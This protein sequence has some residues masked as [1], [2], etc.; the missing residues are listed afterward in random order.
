MNKTIIILLAML[1]GATLNFPSVA[2]A[3]E[4]TTTLSDIM[5]HLSRRDML[6]NPAYLIFENCNL[7]GN[8]LV[9]DDIKKSERVNL[10]LI[11]VTDGSAKSKKGSHFEIGKRLSNGVLLRAVAMMTDEGNV[12]L[13]I[14]FTSR[15]SFNIEDGSTTNN[16]PGVKPFYSSTAVYFPLKAGAINMSQDLMFFEGGLVRNLLLSCEVTSQFAGD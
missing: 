1:T 14:G 9:G 11:D 2:H 6:E 10:K 13:F 7:T 8:V 16:V 12:K 3:Q 4:G 5:T 15:D